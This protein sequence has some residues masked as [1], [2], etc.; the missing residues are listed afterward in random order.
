[1]GQAIPETRI[2]HRIQADEDA[3]GPR[4][5]TEIFRIA[6][7]AFHNIVKHARASAASLS[8]TLCEGNLL[9]EIRNNG[10]GV[11][12][13]A[14]T[15]HCGMGLH[16]MRERAELS[17]GELFVISRDGKGVSIVCRWPRSSTWIR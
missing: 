1:M 11:T 9:F 7:E 16:S 2:E 15:S 13:D 4:L 3:F 12:R 5:K 17:G 14:G 10:R 8:L 6:Q